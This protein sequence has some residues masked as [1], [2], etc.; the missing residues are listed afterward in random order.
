MCPI[1]RTCRP[2]ANR[3]GEELLY[4]VPFD[5]RLIASLALYTLA[6]NVIVAHN[7]PSG[8]L[9]PGANDVTYTKQIKKALNLIEVR[10]WDHLII[11]DRN[12]LSMSDEMG[13][14]AHIFTGTICRR[15][16]E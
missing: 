4:G 3:S 5:I 1:P 2:L 6:T 13:H 15:L 11:S 10:L 7:H 8:E 9:T 12:Y 14:G 16:P